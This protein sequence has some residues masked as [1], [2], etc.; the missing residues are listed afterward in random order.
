LTYSERRFALLAN[1]F[2]SGTLFIVGSIFMASLGKS[3]LFPLLLAA[4]VALG[5]AS[6]ASAA[7]FFSELAHF[8]NPMAASNDLDARQGSIQE[9][10]RDAMEAGRLTDE[11]MHAIQLQLQ[12][13]AAEEALAKSKD[14]ELSYH[15][16]SKLQAELDRISKELEA[17][18]TERKSGP[19]DV[20]AM[21]DR[22]ATR[23]SDALAVHKVSQP[24]YDQ[25][26]AA[27]TKVDKMIAQAKGPD[28]LL[29]I[30]D[31]VRIALDLDNLSQRFTAGESQRKSDM[32]AI[33][34]RR[35][36][37]RALIREG[38]A[39]VNLPKMRWMICGSSYTLT[40]IKRPG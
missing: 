21:R 15:Q 29:T 14:G 18:L 9:R 32:S 39:N 3:R 35:D 1:S 25:F 10:L 7:G 4:T 6:G 12:K 19:V 8:S 13:I 33:D 26:L 38:V 40:R 27:L 5:S 28:G 23:L 2:L 31:Q 17:D 30:N 20:V 34:E 16:T 24:A 22:L 11:N 37:L 36:E